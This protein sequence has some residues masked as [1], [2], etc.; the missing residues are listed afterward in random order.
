MQKKARGRTYLIEEIF[1]KRK[2][3]KV[4]RERFL[5]YFLVVFLSHPC[6]VVEVFSID[7]CG[8]EVRDILSL[9]LLS[10]VFHDKELMSKV[11]Y[12]SAIGSLMYAMV[13]TR[14]DIAIAVGA[15]SR[16]MSIP[17]KKHW[18]VVKLISKYLSDTKDKCLCLARGGLY[19]RIHRFGLICWMC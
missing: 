7:L 13:A 11:P 17:C 1:I 10:S 5:V 12:Q 14:L 8:F 4:V 3:S 6:S 16:L 19:H 15:V 9:F 18:D 2:N